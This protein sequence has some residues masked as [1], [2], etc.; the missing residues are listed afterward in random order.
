MTVC[1]CSRITAKLQ[2]R[3][4]PNFLCMIPLAM[5][6]SC[7]L[8]CVKYFRLWWHNVFVAQDQSASV[9]HHIAFRWSSPGGSTRWMSETTSVWVSSSEGSTGGKVCYLRLPC[10]ILRCADRD[11]TTTCR[12]PWSIFPRQLE[13]ASFPSWLLSPRYP[14]N[15]WGSVEWNCDWMLLGIAASVCFGSPS[16]V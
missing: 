11:I 15:L 10:W 3:S 4:S 16:S 14:E 2:G 7:N 1:M 9:E 5:A 8:Q 13:S 6:R 12:P